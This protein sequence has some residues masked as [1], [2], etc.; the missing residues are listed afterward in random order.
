MGDMHCVL[1]TEKSINTVGRPMLECSQCLPTA[2]EHDGFT[3][4]VPEAKKFQD[5]IIE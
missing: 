2:D 4:G 5:C 3:G 1:I